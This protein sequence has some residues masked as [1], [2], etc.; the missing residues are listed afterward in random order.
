MDYFVSTTNTPYDIWQVELLIESFKLHNLQDSLAIAVAGESL[1]T[2]K[3][4]AKHKRILYHTP[5]PY[6]SIFAV[7]AALYTGFLTEPFVLMHPDM[8]L[9]KPFVD[10]WKEN[11]VFMCCKNHLQN[12]LPFLTSG[13]IRF[14]LVA[15]K[16]FQIA[17]AHA[18]KL[19]KDT[20]EDKHDIVKIAW[21]TS[22]L[23]QISAYEVTGKLL[24]IPLT[25][26]DTFEHIP[27]I[28]YTSGIPPAFN[29]NMFY[30]GV[31]LTDKDPYQV[32]LEQ[33]QTEVMA[34]VH[35][36]INSYQE[37]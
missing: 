25:H 28:H 18:I 6:N 7:Y 36:V 29:K 16:F 14:N 11:I 15:H 31:N 3:N 23:Q 27:F 34:Y 21:T 13:A 1:P 8:I 30:K 19:E 2:T 35:K 5:H 37:N 12:Q 33:N 32:L 22:I 9:H 4:L 17:L 26:I 10:N 24:E 20:Q